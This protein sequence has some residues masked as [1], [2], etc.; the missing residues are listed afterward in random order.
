MLLEGSGLRNCPDPGD[1]QV[2]IELSAS[3]CPRNVSVGFGR[4]GFFRHSN[5]IAPIAA[6]DYGRLGVASARTRSTDL[7]LRVCSAHIP[8]PRGDLGPVLAGHRSRYTRIDDQFYA[9]PRYDH[10]KKI[11]PRII[12]ALETARTTDSV[13]ETADRRTPHLNS[14]RSRLRSGRST[15]DHLIRTR[16]CRT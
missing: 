10:P 7:R 4:P 2:Q 14:T 8:T 5:E 13:T 11:V 3:T 12:A 6:N 9:L 1:R 16:R 15:P